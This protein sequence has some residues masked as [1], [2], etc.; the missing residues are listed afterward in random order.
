MAEQQEVNEIAEAVHTTDQ[1][2]TTRV[3]LSRRLRSFKNLTITDHGSWGYRDAI[4]SYDSGTPEF[5]AVLKRLVEWHR[6]ERSADR[7]VF[8]AH[9]ECRRCSR[10]RQ[11]INQ[12]IHFCG[13]CIRRMGADALFRLATFG[14]QHAIHADVSSHQIPCRLCQQSGIQVERWTRCCQPCLEGLDDEMLAELILPILAELEKRRLSGALKMDLPWVV[15]FEMGS[16]VSQPVHVG[17]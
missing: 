14:I 9:G 5:G 17:G 7:T 11:N 10:Y 3:H 13:P 16:N 4:E 1:A 8:P 6:R 12:M 2:A 15:E